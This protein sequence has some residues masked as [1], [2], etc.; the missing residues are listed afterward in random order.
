VNAEPA[1]PFSDRAPAWLWP[2]VL[3]LLPFLWFAVVLAPHPLGLGLQHGNDF[4]ACRIWW[5]LMGTIGLQHGF[6]PLWNILQDYGAV[7]P[8]YTGYNFF[9]PFTWWAHAVLPWERPASQSY[10][11]Y[12]NLGLH[13]AWALNG[14]YFWLR[15]QAGVSPSAAALGAALVMLNQR[16]N[17]F[18]RYPNGIEA[19]AWLPWALLALG[20]L[21]DAEGAADARRRA[22]WALALALCVGLSWVAGYGQLTYIA[23]LLFGAVLLAHL[24]QPRRWMWAVGALGVGS[25]AA[26]GALWPIALHAFTSPERGGGDPSFALNHP[27]A[28]GYFRMFTHPFH[29]D[30]HASTWFPPAYLPLLLLGGVAAWRRADRRWTLGLLAAVGV[31]GDL[32]LGREGFLFEF[33]HTHVPLYGAFRTQGRNNWITL[34]A[35][36]WFAAAGVEA[37]NRAGPR[38]RWGLGLAMAFTA[39][40]FAWAGR[41]PFAPRVASAIEVFG[42]GA[43]EVLRAQDRLLLGTTLL[44]AA[45]CLVRHAGSRAVLLALQIPVLV[46]VWAR[47]TTDYRSWPTWAR[48]AHYPDGLLNAHRVGIGTVSSP[49]LEYFLEP[50]QRELDARGRGDR[51]PASRFLFAPDT[52][53]GAAPTLRLVSHGPNH[54]IADLQAPAAGRLLHIAA[55][56]SGWRSNLPLTAAPPPLA[57]LQML[58]LPAGETRLDLRFRPTGILLAG[59]FTLAVLPGLAAAWLA[60]G[61]HRRSARGLVAAAVLLPALFLAGTVTTHSWPERVLYGAD[62]QSRDPGGK[63]P[64][65]DLPAWPPER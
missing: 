57:P 24:D 13:M 3:S 22:R 49:L 8:G 16:F 5:K 4:Q 17:D 63:V 58:A 39:V 59:G 62:G 23:F 48:I 46:L 56:H 43:A 34:L 61:G 21:L 6:T 18:I 33:F 7:Y 12:L 38:G 51:F 35:L 11:E 42:L 28:V 25:L 29:A 40:G 26:V 19:L 52:P 45:A 64:L 14:V 60:L 44:L 37:A 65:A 50:V 15:R 53:G 31:I 55:H 2:A 9:Y 47:W 20:R 27:L 10:A 30:P 36:A 1:A 32:G 54:L 41:T